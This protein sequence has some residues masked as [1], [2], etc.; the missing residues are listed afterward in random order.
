[1]GK[2]V[3]RVGTLFL[4]IMCQQSLHPSRLFLWR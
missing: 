2:F 3:L 1:L 4:T